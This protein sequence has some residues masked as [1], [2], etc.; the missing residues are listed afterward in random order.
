VWLNWERHQVINADYPEELTGG[1]TTAFTL[2]KEGKPFQVKIPF[3]FLFPHKGGQLDTNS[4]LVSTVTNHAEGLWVEWN[5][6]DKKSWMQQL[7]TDGYY[8]AYIHGQDDNPYPYDKGH[9]FLWNVFLQTKWKA[10]LLA[11]YWRGHHFIAPRGGKLFQSISSIT[12]LP[13]YTEPDRQLFFLTMGYEKEVMPG[14]FLDFRIS[15]Y[16]DLKNNITEPAFLL[17]FS[18]R[19]QFKLGTLK[20]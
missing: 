13:N 14:F 1:F 6:P 12:T 9:G 19:G 10:Y 2:T 7:R 15:P 3:Q 18:Y 17:L 5:N 20:K 8:A 16:R 4:A 11:T